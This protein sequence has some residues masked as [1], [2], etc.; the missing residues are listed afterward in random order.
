MELAT[1]AMSSLL[2]KLA[3]LLQKEYNLQTGLKTDVQSLSR[4]LE[5]IEVALAKVAEVPL[6]QLDK[7]VRLWA[8]NVKQLSYEMEDIVDSF[9]VRVEGSKPD[10]DLKN[11]KRFRK[12]IANFFKKGKT[13]RQIADKIQDIKV[14]VKEVADLRDRYKVDDVRA[15]PATTNTVDP[16][17][18]ALFKD[19]K[20]LVGI[21]EPRNEV[22]KR[23]MMEGDDD[24]LL[25]S[26]MQLK[27]LSIFGFG[28]LGKTTLAKAVYDMQQ[29]NFVCKAFVS[30]GQNPSLKKVFMDI[31]LQ[32]DEA[33]SSSNASMLNEEQL[34]RKLRR[35]LENKRYLIVID[36]IWDKIPWDIMKCALVDSNC[37]SRI[38][39][40][41]RIL[42]VAEEA[43]DVYKQKPLSSATSKE[44]FYTRLSIGKC[45][46]TSGQPIE[47]SDK[48]LQKCGGVPLAI[49]TI[50]SLL[51]SKPWE[52]WSEVYD[53]IGFRDGANIHVENTRKILLYSYYDLPCYLR[54]C[55]LHLSIYPEDHEIRKDTLI[56]KWVA[57]G[58]VHEKPGMGLFEQGERYFNELINRSL[59][60]PVEEP[61]KSIIYACRVHDLVLDMICRLSKEENFV[62][63]H[64]SSNTEHQPSQSNVRRL[65][66]QNIAMDEEPNSDNTE[67]RQVRSFNA[68]MCDV[69]RR[70]FLSSFQGLRILSMERCTFINDGSCHLENLGRL[71]Q[72]RYLGLLETRITELPE[73]IGNLRFL[74][75]LDLRD[76]KIKELPE[77]VGQLRR[78]KCLRLS[79]GFKGA[80]GWIGNL[81]LLEEL[82]LPYFSLEI[83]K[84]L[85]KL[86]ELREY[87]DCFEVSDDALVDISILFNNMMES[88][89]HLQKLQTIQ[90]IFSWRRVVQ[91]NCVSYVLCRHLRRLELQVV[92]EKLPVW[93]NSSS[94]PNLSHLTF[95]SNA[96]EAQDMEVL[97]R[98]P[99]L[100]YLSLHTDP[101]VIIPDIMGGGAFPKLRYYLTNASARFLQGAMPSLERVQYF[102]RGECSGAKFER[103]IASIGNLPCLDRVQVF[104]YGC[105]RVTREKG[106]AA[107]RQAVEVHP[108][109]ITVQLI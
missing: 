82:F 96:V 12:K 46:I 92:F 86:T 35:F 84:E 30:V 49:I 48:I 53:S 2:P 54:A 94:L 26:R 97:G 98:F 24:G 25:N 101:D 34:I 51:A 70:S 9:M 6:D 56:W 10:A 58:F 38:I 72:L 107:L 89:E 50:A 57:E 59:I 27:I 61:Y 91:A 76:T 13:R 80:L 95:A 20:E 78:L 41:T 79:R 83:V 102:I 31:L 87:G 74:E 65:A 3:E 67:I 8:R 71:L 85:A 93:I 44:L 64:G 14:R 33:E 104:F 73:E 62:T 52:D 11:S 19:Q 36:D 21:E 32:V 28:G 43:D 66:L 42:E 60:Q 103:D 105:E 88:L 55:L 22:I 4:E 47:I 108:N 1:G 18:M 40:T 29:S 5:S 16:R 90:V 63:I 75:V 15:N 39:T 81:V 69:K 23:L 68:I 17:I 45:N 106:E 100:I 77:S 7:Q 37:G 99:E 109:N